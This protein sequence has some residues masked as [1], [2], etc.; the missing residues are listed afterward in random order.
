MKHNQLTSGFKSR[1]CL[2]GLKGSSTMVS[3]N[4]K[5]HTPQVHGNKN[6][7]SFVR[8][9]LESLRITYRLLGAK[10][11]NYPASLEPRLAKLSDIELVQCYKYHTSKYIQRFAV[12]SEKISPPP[13]YN[14]LDW[15]F[16]PATKRYLG[17]KC[18]KFKNAF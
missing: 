18:M 15:F 3:D 7:N 5:S 11:H 2:K 6:Q 12:E 14:A 10:Q 9:L 8:S 16:N 4:Q 17:H 1:P 13:S